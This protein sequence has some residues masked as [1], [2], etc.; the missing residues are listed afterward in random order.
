MA[1]S[2]GSRK[3]KTTESPVLQENTTATQNSGVELN[4]SE[5]EALLTMIK[6]ST[7]QGDQV[8]HVYNLVFKLQ[9][10]YSTLSY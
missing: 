3:E 6:V 10:Y 1:F 9:Q 4:K 7:F 8:E 5:I 2:F